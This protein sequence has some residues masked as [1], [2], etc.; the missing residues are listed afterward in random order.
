MLEGTPYLISGGSSGAEKFRRLLE[1]SASVHDRAVWVGQ[2]IREQVAGTFASFGLAWRSELIAESNRLEYFDCTAEEVSETA[3]RYRELLKLPV[4]AF[5][6]SVRADKR[7]YEALQVLGL[8]R[9]QLLAEEWAAAD[10]PP[11]E[12]EI[13]QLHGLIT[14]GAHYAG[15][16]KIAPNQI[17]GSDHRPPAPAEAAEGMRAL[18]E[19]WRKGTSDPALDAT[20]VHAWLTHLHPFDDGNGRLARLLANLSLSRRSYPPLIIRADMDRDEYYDALIRSDD[21][22][23]LPLFEFFTRV[24]RRAARH[25]DGDDY[26]EKLVGE[27]ML[28]T[29]S[30]RHQMWLRV[31]Q[32]FAEDLAR[33][34][35]AKD[36]EIHPQKYPSARSFLELTKDSNAGNSWFLKIGEK[37]TGQFWLLWFGYNSFEYGEVFK[38]RF[39]YPSI[40][41]SRPDASPAAF[42]TYSWLTELVLVP[43]LVRPARFRLGGRWEELTV[44]SA[45]KEAGRGLVAKRFAR[46][47]Q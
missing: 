1:R 38:E 41:F 17:T 31:A 20:I 43:G 26:V 28:R 15:R 21:G 35:P 32:Q 42:R 5:M 47:Q 30:D 24:V 29:R 33:E 12:I 10:Y 36:W 2:R 19:W 25:M 14:E 8:Y 37:H 16:Y 18:S 7:I 6:L 13:R 11:C 27:Q 39:K 44:H 45:A 23:I 46:Y 9:A 3:A 34:L 40:F 4:H 22:D